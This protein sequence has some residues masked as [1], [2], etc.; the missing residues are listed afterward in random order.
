MASVVLLLRN[1]VMTQ[2]LRKEGWDEEE[3]LLSN[4]TF[5]DVPLSYLVLD[6][7]EKLSYTLFPIRLCNVTQTLTKRKDVQ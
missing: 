4:Q 1:D 2:S 6:I 5:N 7:Q 3:M